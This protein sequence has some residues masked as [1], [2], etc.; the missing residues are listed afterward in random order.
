MP[1]F[2][3]TFPLL[4]QLDFDAKPRAWE[5]ACHASSLPRT[6][7]HANAE[8]SI[9]R[10]FQQ[11]AAPAGHVPQQQQRKTAA[12]SPKKRPPPE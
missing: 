9:Q 3:V 5:A 12:W 11:P 6:R 2:D 7:R 10:Y 8:K 1:F 4:A